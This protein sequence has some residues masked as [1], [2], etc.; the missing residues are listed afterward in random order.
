MEILY[1][2]SRHLIAHFDRK[3]NR[4][5]LRTYIKAGS[6]NRMLKDMN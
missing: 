2:G 1:P 5:Y 4:A 3:L 6:L